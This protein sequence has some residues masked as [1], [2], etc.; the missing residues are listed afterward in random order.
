MGGGAVVFADETVGG[1]RT[2]GVEGREGKDSG[3]TDRV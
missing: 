1:G 3:L 2:I